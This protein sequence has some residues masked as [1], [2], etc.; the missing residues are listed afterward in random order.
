LKG[1]G[2]DRFL[3]K[4]VCGDYLDLIPEIPDGSLDLCVTDP[5]YDL[6]LERAGRGIASRPNVRIYARLKQD[7]GNGFDP[8]AMLELLTL[9]LKKFNGY[10]WICNRGKREIEAT[11]T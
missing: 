6:D 3:N 2:L 11:N 4:V 5:P 1:S 9:K 10:F 7:F 8:S